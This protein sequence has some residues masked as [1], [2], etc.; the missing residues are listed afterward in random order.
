LSITVEQVEHV[1]HLARLNLTDEEKRE[2]AR[3]LSQIL[4]LVDTLRRLDVDAV[5]PTAHLLSVKNVFRQDVIWE[6]LS[7]SEV[8]D[9]A[10]DS[11]NGCFRVPRITES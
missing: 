2:F 8:L 6:S 1:A 11:E 3:E 10:P 9:S 7:Q 4:K 5:E